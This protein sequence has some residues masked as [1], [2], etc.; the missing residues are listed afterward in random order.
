[1]NGFITIHVVRCP[2]LVRLGSMI[3]LMII[4]EASIFSQNIQQRAFVGA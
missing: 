3:L 1:M 4:Q 2:S